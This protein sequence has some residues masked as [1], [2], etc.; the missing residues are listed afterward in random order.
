VDE[1]KDP[2]IDRRAFLR[3]AVATGA[4]AWA[5]PVV[6]TIAANP[7]Y[8]QT[9]GTPFCGHSCGAVSGGPAGCEGG[10]KAACAIACGDAGADCT[11]N[12]GNASGGGGGGG[13]STTV[14]GVGVACEQVCGGNCPVGQGGN[15]PCC[16]SGF[17]DVGNWEC[18]RQRPSG[19]LVV[20]LEYSGSQGGC[21]GP[22]VLGTLPS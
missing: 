4:A 19:G 17:C 8:A 14:G 5:A 15:N 12:N 9:N 10:C 20:Y 18:V 11:C 7:A 3:R 13:S 6:Q 21:P 22:F 1:V 2:R 16:N